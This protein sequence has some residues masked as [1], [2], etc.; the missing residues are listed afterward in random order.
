MSVKARTITLTMSEQ[1]YQELSTRVKL[2]ACLGALPNAMDKFLLT[3][4]AAMD[5]G[6]T[7][8]NVVGV[9]RKAKPAPKRKR[10]C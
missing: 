1:L 2:R 5:E 7:E 6:K 10:R 4:F 9:E 8:V 3:V